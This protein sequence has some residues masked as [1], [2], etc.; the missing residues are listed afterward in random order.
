MALAATSLGLA[1]QWVSATASPLVHPLLKELLG[2]PQQLEL[3][4]MLALGYPAGAPRKRS[5]R[6]KAEMVHLDHFD[7]K[8]YRDEKQLRDFVVGLRRR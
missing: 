6:E 3:Y 5:V 7:P 8:K 4:D 1:S 2:I